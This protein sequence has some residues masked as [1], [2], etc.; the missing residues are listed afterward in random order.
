MGTCSLDNG[1]ERLGWAKSAVGLGAQK[2]CTTCTNCSAVKAPPVCFPSFFTLFSLHMQCDMGWGHTGGSTMWSCSGS[3]TTPA[4]LEH[5]RLPTP[6][7]TY[8][9][10]PIVSRKR[11]PCF[12]LLCMSE[13]S[14]VQ[15]GLL[16][17]LV[18]SIF[19]LIRSLEV[20]LPLL[21]IDL[22]SSSLTKAQRRSHRSESH[23]T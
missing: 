1:G 8:E 6:G 20:H 10:C 3:K 11:A 15:K 23:S 12:I 22:C 2:S 19:T 13:L 7:S 5:P 21:I 9:S 18:W 14:H 17:G 16:S 4:L